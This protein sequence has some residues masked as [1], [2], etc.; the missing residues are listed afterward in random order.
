MIIS[1][2]HL[3]ICT[4]RIT[5]HNAIFNLRTHHKNQY[6]T[7]SSLAYSKQIVVLGIEIMTEVGKVWLCKKKRV[8]T[9]EADWVWS[10]KLTISSLFQVSDYSTLTW[11]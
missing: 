8:Y 10:H 1:S 11:G 5:T 7:Y 3:Y 9:L 6:K 4:M 2:S